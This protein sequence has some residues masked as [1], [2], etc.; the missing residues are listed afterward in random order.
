M[1]FKVSYDESWHLVL[2]L[3][4]K[5]S[6]IWFLDWQFDFQPNNHFSPTSKYKIVFRF[7][8]EGEEKGNIEYWCV[9]V[10]QSQRKKSI[11]S[12]KLLKEWLGD[13]HQRRIERHSFKLFLC[14]WYD[15]W[16]F[17]EQSP[18]PLQ[19]PCPDSSDVPDGE[20]QILSGRVAALSVIGKLFYNNLKILF[21]FYLLPYSHIKGRQW[22]N[23]VQFIT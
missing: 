2:K 3:K 13:K 21:R 11:I 23:N 16:G 9:G 20:N 12:R 18:P 5:L 22:P 19:C 14:T 7:I 15:C 4:L 1:I 8:A 6:L 10:N 17:L